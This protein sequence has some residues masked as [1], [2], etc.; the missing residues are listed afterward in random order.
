MKTD[1]EL[2]DGL[3]DLCGYVEDGS[4][5]RVTILQDDATKDWF[6]LVESRT[7]AYSTGFRSVISDAIDLYQGESQ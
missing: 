7:I 1:K 5:A 6:L 3:R 2:L 4:S